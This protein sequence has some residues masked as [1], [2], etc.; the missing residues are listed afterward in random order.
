MP[1]D[2]VA[3][4]RDLLMC[5]SVTPAEGGALAFLEGLLAPAGFTVDRPV[6]SDAGTP[7]IENLFAGIGAGNRHLTFAGH[8]DVVPPGKP[9][10]WPTWCRPA[11][12][13]CGATVRL[14]GTSRAIGSMA[15]APST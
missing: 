15:A 2:P 1:H 12:R 13:S 8:T 11:S 6:F 10:L 14:T 4:A 9:E 3:I 7:D 5:P